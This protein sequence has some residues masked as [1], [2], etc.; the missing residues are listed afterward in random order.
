MQAP[1]ELLAEHARLERELADP[2]VHSDQAVARR[3]G[4][5][6]AE[7]TPVVEAHRALAELEG[8]LAAARELA[9]EDDSFHAEV[10]SLVA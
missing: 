7:L 8:D 3:L 2:G 1:A 5:R 9:A 4:K 10:A 6:Y